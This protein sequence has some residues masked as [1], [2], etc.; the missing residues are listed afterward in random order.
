MAATPVR[1]AAAATPITIAA[2]EQL[3]SECVNGTP[4]AGIELVRRLWSLAV[5]DDDKMIV[6]LVALAAPETLHLTSVQ[7]DRLAD[8]LAAAR[9]IRDQE[10]TP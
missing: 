5:P 2:L 3:A 10:P 7:F 4:D 1:P 9:V 6:G 8:A